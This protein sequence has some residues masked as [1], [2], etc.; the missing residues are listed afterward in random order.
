M[1]AE[2][3]EQIEG[4]EEKRRKRQGWVPWK[5][6]LV[7]TLVLLLSV[8]VAYQQRPQLRWFAQ[9]SPLLRGIGIGVGRGDGST[10][11]SCG[12]Q[13][14]ILNAKHWRKTCKPLCVLWLGLKPV[15]WKAWKKAS[16]WI[17]ICSRLRVPFAAAAEEEELQQQTIVFLFQ[18]WSFLGLFFFLASANLPGM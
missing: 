18:I 5:R 14:W 11:S 6:I 1:S 12:C 9:Q 10:S 13:V 2:A 4:E 17:W 3:S 8:G 7:A 16:V 15:A